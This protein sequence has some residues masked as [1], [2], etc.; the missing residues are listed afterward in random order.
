[1]NTTYVVSE[2]HTVL[3]SRARTVA[4]P[5]PAAAA[6]GSGATDRNVASGSRGPY[7]RVRSSL[8]QL[9][10]RSS[11]F[12]AVI[13]LVAMAFVVVAGTLH[14]THAMAANAPAHVD[15]HADC[16]AAHH[17][18]HAHGSGHDG[19]PMGQGLHC[20]ACALAKIAALAP[21]PVAPATTAPVGAVVSA[22]DAPRLSSHASRYEIA[23][24]PR[25]PPRPPMRPSRDGW[26]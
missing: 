16:L 6:N 1:M 25:A 24:R 20:P 17:E 15:P 7:V 22:P 10:R 12:T 23:A 3:T 13:A 5:M 26:L 11:R 14:V 9:L 18:A 4:E 8:M 2:Y 19:S 21:P